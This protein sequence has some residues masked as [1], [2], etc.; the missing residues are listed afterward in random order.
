MQ[1][2]YGGTWYCPPLEEVI[3]DVGLDEMDTYISRI[4]N[5]VAQYIVM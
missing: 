3:W 4:Q 1:L 5:M 2:W